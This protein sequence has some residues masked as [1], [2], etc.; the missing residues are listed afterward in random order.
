MQGLTWRPV[1]DLLAG[2]ILNCFID[3]KEMGVRTG[4]K[5]ARMKTSKLA[6]DRD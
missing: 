3:L 4:D 2:E 1:V 5:L 6:R